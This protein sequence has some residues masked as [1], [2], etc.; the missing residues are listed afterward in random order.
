MVTILSRGRWV[1]LYSAGPLYICNLT[2]TILADGLAPNGA[3]PLAA[4]CVDSKITYISFD[5]SVA[6]NYS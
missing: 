1:K 3:K 6:T 4:I 2:I 5:V